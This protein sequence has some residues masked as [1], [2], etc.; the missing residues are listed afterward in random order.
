MT[1]KQFQLHRVEKGLT[2]KRLAIE[3]CVSKPT[4]T[5]WETSQKPPLI[6]QKLFCLIYD[7]PFKDPLKHKKAL[8]EV[9]DLPFK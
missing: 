7:I 4:L 5:R 2:Q 6:A 3:L 9:P 1:S 8:A